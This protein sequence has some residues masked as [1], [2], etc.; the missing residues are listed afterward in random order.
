MP[1]FFKGKHNTEKS[2]L[3]RLLSRGLQSK[4]HND[5]FYKFDGTNASISHILGKHGQGLYVF[6]DIYRKA[7]T[8]DSKSDVES[9]IRLP[10]FL[11]MAL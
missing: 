8:E 3:A 2:V 11:A 5:Y 10:V 4:C 1:W 9:S 6:D 7:Q